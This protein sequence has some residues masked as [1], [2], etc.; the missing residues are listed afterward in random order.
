MRF[1]AKEGNSGDGDLHAFFRIKGVRTSAVLTVACSV[2]VRVL[3]KQRWF[4]AQTKSL[5]YKRAA[6]GSPKY[7]LL[8][9]GG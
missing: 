4:H 7:V 2:K 3:Q 1:T 9:G 5:C 8:D 6:C